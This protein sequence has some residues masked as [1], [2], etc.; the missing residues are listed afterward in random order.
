VRELLAFR[1]HLQ[2]RVGVEHRLD[3]QGGFRAAGFQ[4]GT[5][6][7]ALEQ[8][9]LGVQRQAALGLALLRRVALVALLGEDGADLAFEKLSLLR[10]DA[11]SG[12][13]SPREHEEAHDGE[14]GT[15]THRGKYKTTRGGAAMHLA[16]RSG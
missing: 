8:A 10:R 9:G 11:I 1:R 2:V 4:A 5:G 3:Q 13:R 15:Y 16:G 14:E 12:G 7:A 6:V